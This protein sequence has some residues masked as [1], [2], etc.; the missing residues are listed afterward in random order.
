MVELLRPVSGEHLLVTEGVR[1]PVKFRMPESR[2][3]RDALETVIRAGTGPLPYRAFSGWWLS[4]DFPRHGTGEDRP[5][6]AGGTGFRIHYGQERQGDP[7]M[8][9]FLSWTERVREELWLLALDRWMIAFLCNRLHQYTPPKG[10]GDLVP[11]CL[12]SLTTMMSD[13]TR[14]LTPVQTELLTRTVHELSAMMIKV[15][16][17]LEGQLTPLNPV[18]GFGFE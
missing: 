18:S 16:P 4:L 7:M 5:I 3:H 12:P 10:K 9:G 8:I 13:A 11:T 1:Y 6:R 2:D 14:D 15:V 17:T